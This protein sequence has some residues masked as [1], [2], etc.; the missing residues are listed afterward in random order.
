MP[1]PIVEDGYSFEQTQDAAM[2]FEALLS[3]RG[4]QLRPGSLLEA[5]ILGVVDIAYK[6]AGL[7]PKELA[8]DVRHALRELVGVNELTQ[9]VLA[10]QA[11]PDFN[12]LVPHLRLLNEGAALQ[13]APS[14]QLDDASRKVFELFAASLAMQTGTAIILEDPK[15]SANGK[16]PDVLATLCSEQWGI[17]CKVVHSLHPEAFIK[18]LKKGIDQIEA[19]PASVGV[20]LINLKN[21][22]DYENLWPI[23]TPLGGAGEPAE[24]AAFDSPEEP[25]NRLLLQMQHIGVT[26]KEYL[27]ADHLETFFDGKKSIRG[28]LLW[29]HAM[30]GVVRNGR[31]TPSSLR[32]MNLQTAGAVSSKHR[33]VLERLNWAAFP[34][35]PTRGEMPGC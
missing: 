33:R 15:E 28:F 27:P 29:G 14:S 1:D 25:Y 8:G 4:I 17:A 16:N 35:S 7:G 2:A 32:V 31:P 34:D 30:T 3:R 13:N 21:V 10:V 22:L 26:L 6:R 19:S 11:H 12:Q 24:Y 23:V 5:A 9:L 18:N 20:V